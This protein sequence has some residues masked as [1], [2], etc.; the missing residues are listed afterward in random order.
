MEYAL[1]H[2]RPRH[3]DNNQTLVFFNRKMLKYQY[4]SGQFITIDESNTIYHRLC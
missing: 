2:R 4:I 3:S 1:E